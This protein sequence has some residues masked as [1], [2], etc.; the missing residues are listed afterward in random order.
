MV[1]QMND[2]FFQ[3]LQSLFFHK[4]LPD[5]FDVAASLRLFSFI[6]AFFDFI[7]NLADGFFFLFLFG[8]ML[9]P[10]GKKRSLRFARPD[11]HTG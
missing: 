10:G 7:E 4:T 1:L 5:S 2:D 3:F 6:T 9:Y 11:P 8:K